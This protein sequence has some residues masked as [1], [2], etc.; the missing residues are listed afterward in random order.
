MRTKRAIP[1]LLPAAAAPVASGLPAAPALARAAS[2]GAVGGGDPYYPRQGNGGYQVGHY[3]L[4]VSYTPSSHH[5]S[6][7]AGIWARVGP[8][9]LRRFDLDLRRN[10]RVRSVVVDGQAA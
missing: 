4:R 9:A 8:T 1:V 2:V 3:S 10:L 7:V 6:G 5:L